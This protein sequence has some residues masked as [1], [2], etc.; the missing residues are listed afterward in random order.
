[1]DIRIPDFA[2]TFSDNIYR[3]KNHIVTQ[4]MKYEKSDIYDNTLISHDTYYRRTPKRDS[5]YKLLFEYKTILMVNE[6]RQRH[7]HASILTK[8][9]REMGNCSSLFFFTIKGL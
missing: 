9:S 7:I 2:A 1:M 6:Y 8:I 5:E 4:H 3:T